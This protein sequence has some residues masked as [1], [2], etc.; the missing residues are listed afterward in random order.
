MD[1]QVNK[2]VNDI[3]SYSNRIPDNDLHNLKKNLNAS[4]KMVTP[5]IRSISSKTKKID[6]IKGIINA[7]AIINEVKDYLNLSNKLRFGD[8]EEL[9]N[10]LLNIEQVISKMNVN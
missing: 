2:L 4:A 7:T 6:K 8:T 3:L 1:N 5:S 10:R 9:Q